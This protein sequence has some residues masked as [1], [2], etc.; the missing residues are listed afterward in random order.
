MIL[1]A[2][3][4]RDRVDGETARYVDSYGGEHAF[5]SEPLV[6]KTADLPDPPPALLRVELSWYQA[7]R[8]AAGVKP[9]PGMAGHPI[10]AQGDAVRVIKS[11]ITGVKN[12]P[13]WLEQHLDK[14]GVVLWVTL[15]GANVELGAEA[16][17]FAYDELEW[18][19]P[20]QCG[21]SAPAA[22]GPVPDGEPCLRVHLA[23][24][25]LARG[26]G[27]EQDL[28]VEDQ[29]RSAPGGRRSSAPARPRR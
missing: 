27:G 22:V 4:K 14:T 7:P 12:P 16:V 15:G 11:R 18:L 10:L 21:R 20:E 24:H 17:W 25:R 19:G 9:G 28:H 29:R 1:S 3:L 26:Q 23:D 5:L 13:E 6:L 8:G 2:T